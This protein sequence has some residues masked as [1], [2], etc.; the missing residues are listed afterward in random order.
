[1]KKHDWSTFN[2]RI[3]INASKA[4]IFNS[5]TSQDNLEKWFLSQAEFSS[6]DG[7]V[8]NR[9]SKILKGDTYSW[10][11]HGSENV[12]EGMVRE[13]NGD[14]LLRFTFLGCEVSVEIKEEAGENVVQITQSAIP[15][16]ED[17]TMSYYVGC[18]RGWTFYLANLKSILE[19]G[20]DLRNKNGN[21]TNVINT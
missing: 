7:T 1:M 15:L 18:S 5:W 13:N 8:K 4:D 16:D 20:I 21:L 3:A 2:K 9:G 11:W 17:S 6:H 19:G 12:A 10:M 14:D